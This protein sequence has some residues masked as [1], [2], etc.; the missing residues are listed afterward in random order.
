MSYVGKDRCEGY[1]EGGIYRSWRQIRE[2]YAEE[3]TVDAFRNLVGMQL[4]RWEAPEE[5]EV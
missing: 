4:P 1:F 2:G 5:E 3:G